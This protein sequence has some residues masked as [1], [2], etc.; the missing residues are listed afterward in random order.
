VTDDDLINAGGASY[1][2]LAV[3]ADYSARLE[4]VADHDGPKGPGWKLRL[5][6]EGLPFDFYI[7]LSDASRWKLIETVDAFEPGFF[8]DR[9]EDGTTKRPIDPNVWV[10]MEVGAH[11]ILD[12]KMDTPRKTVESVFSLL[13]V[14]AEIDD[15]PVL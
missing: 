4:S 2:S 5:R 1:E 7:S 3:P 6:V 12:E 9:A 8:E 10:G 11:V 14:E 13:E 15:V